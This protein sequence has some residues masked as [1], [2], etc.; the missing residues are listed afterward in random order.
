MYEVPISYYGRT[1]EQ[2]KKIGTMDGIAA[3]WYILRYNVFSS[4]SSS[5]TTIPRPPSPPA[6]D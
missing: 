4:L 2:G 1:Y 3:F 6:G 5:F